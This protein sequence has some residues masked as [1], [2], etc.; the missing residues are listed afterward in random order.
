M[1][2]EPCP[3][4]H[5]RSHQHQTRL[6]PEEVEELIRDY[7]A[8]IKIN[9]LSVR[10]NIN[11]ATVLKHAKRAGLAKRHPGITDPEEV[12]NRYKAGQSIQTIADALGSC[13]KTVHKVLKDANVAMRKPYDHMLKHRSDESDCG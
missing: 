5:V 12:I 13:N 7:K 10:Y 6:R 1:T 11:R 9:E 4:A 2:P 3:S 8:G